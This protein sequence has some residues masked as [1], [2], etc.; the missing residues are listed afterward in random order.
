MIFLVR[1]FGMLKV[2]L[3]I[4]VNNK[5]YHLHFYYF[6]VCYASLNFFVMF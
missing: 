6:L 2:N 5:S 1:L 4:K 3:I